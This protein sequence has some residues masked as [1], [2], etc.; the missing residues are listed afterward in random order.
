MMRHD[1]IR[2]AEKHTIK[3]FST[4][5]ISGIRFNQHEVSPLPAMAQFPCPAQH[6]FGQIDTINL[7]F[8]SDSVSEKGKIPAG[9]TAHFEDSI[10]PSKFQ[11]THSTLAET[12]WNEKCPFENWNE[13]SNTIVALA[14]NIVIANRPLANCLARQLIDF[15]S[16]QEC[17]Q[18]RTW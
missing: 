6:A 12:R 2:K 11:L 7:S 16:V 1:V 13:C 5:V 14:D 9:P 8:R 10:A 18:V 15:A 3:Q 17:R 4:G